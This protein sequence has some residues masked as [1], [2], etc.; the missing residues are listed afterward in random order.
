[1]SVCPFAGQTDNK[2]IKKSEAVLYVTY[3]AASLFTNV[4]LYVYEKFGLVLC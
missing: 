3:G 2:T 4:M 1:M